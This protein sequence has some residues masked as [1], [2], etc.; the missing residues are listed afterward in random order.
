M[1]W[2]ER[3]A[4]PHS[5]FVSDSADSYAFVWKPGNRPAEVGNWNSVSKYQGNLLQH[6]TH[7]I[8]FFFFTAN[9]NGRK[10][11]HHEP[12]IRLYILYLYQR[13]QGTRLGQLVLSL[14]SWTNSLTGDRGYSNQNKVNCG[15]TQ[16]LLMQFLFHRNLLLNTEKKIL[17]FCS[18]F[19]W[20][21]CYAPMK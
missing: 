21:N 4:F 17:L 13:L 1:F 18:R 6:Y 14:F 7:K 5:D 11:L 9:V 19:V 16:I 10:D 20:W 2:R 8:H 3:G 15:Q 12:E